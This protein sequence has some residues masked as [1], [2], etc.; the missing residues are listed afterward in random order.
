MACP[1]LQYLDSAKKPKIMNTIQVRFPACLRAICTLSGTHTASRG[2]RPSKCRPASLSQ[3][4]SPIYL[5]VRCAMSGT[6]I[7]SRAVPAPAPRPPPSWVG[8]PAW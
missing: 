2:P 8:H 5:R 4:S 7:R 3:V 1:V 6:D